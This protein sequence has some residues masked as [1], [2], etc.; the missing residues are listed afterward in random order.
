VTSEPNTGQA[1]AI[2]SG[3]TLAAKRYA[4]AAFEL[5]REH[6]DIAA[7]QT[8]MVEMAEF[9]SDPEVRRVLLNTRVSQEPKQRLI[10]AAL[11]NLPQRPLNLAR[12]LVRKNRSAL[13][14]EI[15][16]AFNQMAEAER[17]VTRARA[18]TA[19]PLS[20]AEKDALARRLREQTGH[21]VIL[22]F[23]V[24]PSLLGGVVLLMGDRLIDASTR[25]RLEAMRDQ[26]VG[27][28]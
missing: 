2:T 11:G 17:G 28:L 24:D 9:M 25:G 5:A 23:E 22:D 12:L 8:A 1:Q 7:W 16:A 20:D 18:R 10:E 15:A 21:E 6:G 4:L 19:V 26:L 14:A 3:E 27:A 13:A